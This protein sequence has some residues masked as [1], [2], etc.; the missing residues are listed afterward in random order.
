[1][2]SCVVLLF[3]FLNGEVK[4]RRQRKANGV[5]I[6]VSSTYTKGGGGEGHCFALSS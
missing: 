6:L 5:C 2:E 3:L 4:G 1:M